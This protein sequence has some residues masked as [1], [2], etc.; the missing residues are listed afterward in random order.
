MRHLSFDSVDTK[1]TRARARIGTYMARADASQSLIQLASMTIVCTE[2]GTLELRP[3]TSP[4][5]PPTPSPS[6]PPPSPW[7][8]PPSLHSSPSSSGSRPSS[9]S[10]LPSTRE[11]VSQNPPQTPPRAP[12]PPHQP[13]PCR[14]PTVP[15]MSPHAHPHPQSVSHPHPQSNQVPGSSSNSSTMSLGAC[16]RVSVHVCV[17]ARA[18]VSQPS[19]ENVRVY[20]CVCVFG[21]VCPNPRPNP[22]QKPKRLP[23]PTY[24]EV[25]NLRTL[26]YTRTRAC[27]YLGTLRNQNQRLVSQ[28]PRCPRRRRRRIY[29]CCCLALFHCALP[30]P[31]SIRP[32]SSLPVAPPLESSYTIDHS[33]DLGFGTSL[34]TII[35]VPLSGVF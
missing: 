34:S 24:S 32:S 7:T 6:S 10:R 15:L 28:D 17:R 29:A 11:Y 31:L 3:E 21:R 20:V 18:R 5:P 26:H 22:N 12:T 1:H 30:S 13:R 23:N 2:V 27:A 19:P 33:L 16:V 25:P 14:V 35:L 4:L 9:P 8:S